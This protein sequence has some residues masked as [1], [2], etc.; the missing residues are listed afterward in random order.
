MGQSG[1][2]ISHCKFIKCL[3]SRAWPLEM[4]G[5]GERRKWLGKGAT[6]KG[7]TEFGMME[8]EQQPTTWAS[9]TLDLN[10]SSSVG[11]QGP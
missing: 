4:K 7:R 9:N 2:I 8:G 1:D 5:L 10:M 6:G 3:V 11:E